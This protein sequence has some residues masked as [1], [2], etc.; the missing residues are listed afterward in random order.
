MAITTE[1]YVLRKNGKNT[2]VQKVKIPQDDRNGFFGEVNITFNA[3]SVIRT[4]IPR[5]SIPIQTISKA[6]WEKLIGPIQNNYREL[7]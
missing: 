2:T 3:G 1:I 6:E 4:A 7:H 5:Q